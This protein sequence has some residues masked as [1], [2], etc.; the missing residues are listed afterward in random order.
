MVYWN[1]VPGRTLEVYSLDGHL[2]GTVADA[3][4]ESYT[5]SSRLARTIGEP[6]TG[7]FQLTGFK[8]G[9]LYIAFE[10][11]ADFSDERIRLKLTRKQL[12]RQGWHERPSHLP[13]RS[14]RP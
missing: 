13:D 9:D 1:A 4:P 2:V 12:G 5:G 6:G 11:I 3:W 14:A 8:G 10:A 7:Y